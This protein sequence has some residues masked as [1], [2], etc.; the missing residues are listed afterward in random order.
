[1]RRGT[2][3]RRDYAMGSPDG[4]PSAAVDAAVSLAA[5]A[6]TDQR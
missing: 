5:H 2:G 4:Q 1:M 6:T 3:T